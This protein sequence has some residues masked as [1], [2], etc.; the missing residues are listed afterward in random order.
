MKQ[1][2]FPVIFL[3]ISSSIGVQPI[4]GDKYPGG[5]PIL[6]SFDDRFF[7]QHPGEAFD[8]HSMHGQYKKAS[9]AEKVVRMNYDRQVGAM[10]GF[11]GKIIVASMSEVSAFLSGTG[12]MGLT[13]S[14]KIT[15]TKLSLKRGTGRPEK[16]MKSK[17]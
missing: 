8:P 7:D 9:L 17:L 4:S 3:L 2:T 14:V 5:D 16:R 15:K 11:P 12:S 1:F 6:Y 10:R 13:E